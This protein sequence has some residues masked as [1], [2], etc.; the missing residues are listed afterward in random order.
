MST[1]PDVAIVDYG[2]GNLFSIR[3]ACK[4]VGLHAT[5]TSSG[6]QIETARSIILP[7]VGAF[8]DAMDALTR[9]DLIS[10]LRDFAE[11]GKPL[12][13]ICLGLQMLFSKSHEFG[14]HSGL[15][16]ISGNV[17]QLNSTQ[18]KNR[19]LKVPQ[20]G[21]NRIMPP[22]GSKSEWSETI[23]DGIEPGA[24]MYFVHSYSVQPEDSS[25]MLTVTDYGDFRF[26]SGVKYNN[27]YGLQFHPERSSA[28]GLKIYTNFKNL[29]NSNRSGD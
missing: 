1:K 3:Q 2:L 25:M 7:G 29:I 13:G 23:I 22:N 24:F 12:L 21:W 8:G 19:Q 28:E 27:I 15:D 16:L 9:L 5:I 4:H 26:C 20:V 18:Y 10:V 14:T 17:T 6:K 11:S